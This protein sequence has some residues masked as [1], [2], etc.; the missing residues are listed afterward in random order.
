MSEFCLP[1]ELRKKQRENIIMVSFYI[2]KYGL[3]F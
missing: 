2:T 3:P 1:S